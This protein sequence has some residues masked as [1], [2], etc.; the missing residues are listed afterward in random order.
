MTCFEDCVLKRPLKVSTVVVDHHLLLYLELDN[1]K[2]KVMGDYQEKWRLQ[3]ELAR[4]NSWD[5]KEIEVKKIANF[6]CN[7]TF[8]RAQAVGGHSSCSLGCLK[9]ENHFKLSHN[10]I[11]KRACTFGCLA[12]FLYFDKYICI[13]VCYIRLK[14][15]FLAVSQPFAFNSFIAVT[16]WV[17][18]N[19]E[20]YLG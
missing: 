9:T 6:H 15:K 11:S 10:N 4:R 17:F 8:L 1:K 3:N 5:R 13:L 16:F 2:S 18:H 7:F 14:R 12:K 19:L 20:M